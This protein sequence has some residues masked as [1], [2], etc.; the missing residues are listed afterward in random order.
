M[1]SV[2]VA[3][4]HRP[5][6]FSTFYSPISTLS[7]QAPASS[8]R[9]TNISTQHFQ[10]LFVLEVLSVLCLHQTQMTAS[11]QPKSKTLSEGDIGDL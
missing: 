3:F 9:P 2:V 7:P 1:P 10:V 6:A 11:T 8:R 5:T 4:S